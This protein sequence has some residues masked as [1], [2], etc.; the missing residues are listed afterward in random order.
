M[1]TISVSCIPTLA[2]GITGTR[3]R[4]ASLTNPVR[5]A[6]T[7]RLRSENGRKLS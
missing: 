6:K 2:R 7:A 5:P 4:S 3:S 1:R